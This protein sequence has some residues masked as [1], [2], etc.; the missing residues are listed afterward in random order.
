MKKIFTLLAATA[1]TFASI[2]SQAQALEKGD[3]MIDAYY[4]YVGPGLIVRTFALN[5]EG[6]F[7]VVGPAGLRVQ[8]MVAE[9]FGIGIDANY[10]TAKASWSGLSADL[11]NRDYDASYS[12]TKIKFMIRTSWEFVN[13]EKFTMNWANSIGYKN[14]NRVLDANNETFSAGG[15]PAAFRTAVGMRFF[16]TENINI[17][18]DVLGIG[19]GGIFLGGLS[20]KL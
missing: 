20:F 7:S 8:Y 2:N 12:V 9:K 5:E 1:L 18:A 19:G 15:V 3:F 4:G 13:T 17:H 11:T 10:Q 6:D 14:V 16:I